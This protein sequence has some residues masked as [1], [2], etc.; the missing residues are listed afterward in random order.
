MLKCYDVT[1]TVCSESVVE[2]DREICKY[3]FKHVSRQEQATGVDVAFDK[4]TNTK[5]VE[6]CD[7]VSSKNNLLFYVTLYGG[8][9]FI[10]RKF[11]PLRRSINN[12]PF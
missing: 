12:V 1:R 5:A 7:K 8:L 4:T 10:F 11:P 2:E 3:E 9:L 6:I